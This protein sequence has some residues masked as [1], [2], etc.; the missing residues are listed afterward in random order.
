[1]A[2]FKIKGL[3]WWMIG[4]VMLGAIINYLTRSTL[5]VAAPTLLKD[6]NIT[7]QEYSY[8]TAT[9]QGAIMLQ[10][11]AGYVLDVIGLK[12]GFA[13]FATAWS[14]ICMAHGF[15]T[16]WQALAGLR[17]LLGLAEGCANPAGMK[18]VSEWFPAK[19]R[20]LAGGIFNI[21]A[22]FGSMLAPPLVVWA[23]L[24][25][26]WQSAFVITGA[27]GLV[28]V[29]GWLLLYDAPAKHRR[30]SEEE[31]KH[32]VEG[33][34]L[35]LQGDG[36]RPS[37]I[38]IMKMRNFWGIALPRFLADPAWGT[39]AFWVPLYLTTVRHFDL[40]QIAMFAWLPFLAADLGCLFGPTVALALQKRGVKL[41]NARKG[42]FTVGACMMM[43]VA[44]VGFVDSPYAAIALLC[45]A[46]FAHQTLSVTV[47]TM[48]SDLFRRN[49]VAT[50]AGMCGT[51]GN[52][53][54]L[55][56]SLLIGGL[57][58]TVGYTPF[59]VSLAVLDLVAAALLWILV[60]EPKSS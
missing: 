56:F 34:E 2:R 43:G 37:I 36:T 58:A 57:M 15:A 51:F 13:M 45:L 42:A 46:G 35:H 7:A 53:G 29:A 8:I 60:R 30:L 11:L 32:I 1:M 40:T 20:G 31:A 48:A 12:F 19:E 39:L 21:G 54:L 47:I 27:L 59:F 14:M 24:H 10:P 55:L 41:I 23:I 18:A 17:G 5:A 16:N 52:F 38:S 50:V 4:L 3:R 26:N 49:E 33:Q 6:L 22:S 44:F 25:Y 28:W 9:F